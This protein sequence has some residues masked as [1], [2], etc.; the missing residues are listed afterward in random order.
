MM[1]FEMLIAD[2]MVICGTNENENKEMKEEN[3][4]G[5]E[6]INIIP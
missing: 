1:L 4:E 3:E 5:N 2:M 6:N